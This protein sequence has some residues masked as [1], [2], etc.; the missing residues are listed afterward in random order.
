MRKPATKPRTP[1]SNPKRPIEAEQLLKSIYTRLARLN[2]E[3]WFHELSRLYELSVDHHLG[4]HKEHPNVLVDR[5]TGNA[6]ITVHGI[7]PVI[8]FGPED[9]IILPAEMLPALLVQIKVPDEIMFSEFKR[10]LKMAR[11]RYGTFGAKPGPASLNGRIQKTSFARW[12]SDQIVPW[13]DLL[14]WRAALPALERKQYSNSV[15]GEWLELSEKQI[16]AIKRKLI[17]ALESLPA[18][19]AQIPHD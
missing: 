17:K 3:G 13:V 12:R 16:K 1:L 9:Q 11:A 15:L 8:L 7:E 4:F 2:S 5:S 18:L 10:M 14:V 19:A 6:K